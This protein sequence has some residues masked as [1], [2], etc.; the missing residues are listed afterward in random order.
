M[1][2]GRIN[3]RILVRMSYRPLDDALEDKVSFNVTNYITKGVK[4][5]YYKTGVYDIRTAVKQKM[6]A[7]YTYYE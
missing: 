2:R 6:E 3:G 7:R 5:A 4:K 1:K